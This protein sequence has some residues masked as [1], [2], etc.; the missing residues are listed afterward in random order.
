MN[1]YIIKPLVL[2][3]ISS[4]ILACSNGSPTTEDTSSA[5][6]TSIPNSKDLTITPQNYVEI[7]SQLYHN[8]IKAIA[9]PLAEQEEVLTLPV[10]QY[11]NESSVTRDCSVSG[12]F[13]RVLVK[14][15][16]SENT[17]HTGDSIETSYHNCQNFLGTQNGTRAMEIRLMEGIYDYRDYA[18]YTQ[19]R[20]NIT[21]DKGTYSN[22]LPIIF[23]QSNYGD[24]QYTGINV[25]ILDINVT[26]DTYISNVIDSE[27]ELIESEELIAN[28]AYYESPDKFIHTFAFEQIIDDTLYIPKTSYRWWFQVNNK[29]NTSSYSTKTTET[30][31]LEERD[32]LDEDG[33]EETNTVA[34]AGNF[35]VTSET[36]EKIFVQILAH[37]N[38]NPENVIV[39]FDNYGDGIIDDRVIMRWN[40]FESAMFGYMQFTPYPL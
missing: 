11:S 13:T 28:P 22:S 2:C 24:I 3:I 34:L 33:Y 39:S 18:V 21:S 14:H 15:P 23:A 20:R 29:T 7:A 38:D 25:S 16:L 36:G 1:I 6:E 19:V 26:P 9:V 5:F 32:F 40:E 27:L 8:N 10:I 35:N 17:I 30:L 31:V 4:T 37:D 12:E